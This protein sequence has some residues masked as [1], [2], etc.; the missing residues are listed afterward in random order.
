MEPSSLPSVAFWRMRQAGAVRAVSGAALGLD[1]FDGHL[2]EDRYVC[3][4]PACQSTSVPTSSAAKLL[5]NVNNPSLQ[6]NSDNS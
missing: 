2:P 4:S 6:C 5:L 3:I 1:E